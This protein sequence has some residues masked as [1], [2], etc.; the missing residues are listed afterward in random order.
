MH[1]S[2][3]PPPSYWDIIIIN[4]IMVNIAHISRYLGYS[5]FK[6][7]VICSKFSPI[8][9]FN[10][11][12]FHRFFFIPLKSRLLIFYS[13]SE[14]PANPLHCIAKLWKKVHSPTT[15]DPRSSEN[16]VKV[17]VCDRYTPMGG[18]GGHLK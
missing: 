1:Q 2:F 13:T 3:H 12:V 18:V 17:P 15:E 4:I 5:L 16:E 14:I 6:L 9:F 10:N 11:W 8:S 7:S